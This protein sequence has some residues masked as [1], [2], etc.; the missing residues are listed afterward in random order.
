[1]VVSNI[2]K[3]AQQAGVSIATVSR[4]ING[5]ASVSPD[6]Q[7]RVMQAVNLSGYVPSVGRRVTNLIGW[8][9]AGPSSLGSP[10]DAALIEGASD[11]METSGFDLV[12]LNLKRDKQPKE[13]YSQFF[14]RKGVRGAIIRSTARDREVCSAIADEQ[15]PAIV[16]GEHFDHPDISYIYSDSKPTSYQATEHLLALGHTRIAFAASE[17]EDADHTD[18]LQG[19]RQALQEHDIEPDTKL[20][21]RIAARRLDGAQLMRNM[22]CAMHPPTAIFI[23]DPLVAVGAINEAQRLGIRIP[24]DLS[25]VGFDDTDVRNNI[26]PRMTAVCQDARHI[27]NEALSSLCRMLEDEHGRE[28]VRHVSSTWLEVNGTTGAPPSNPFRLLP[29]GT[30]VDLS[31]KI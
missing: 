11:A 27:G 8:V 1:M 5:G 2:R 4:V 13:S 3:V 22:M 10:Y 9:Y 17:T 19:Y 23:A 21:F 30:R 26:Y 12:I 20:Y 31:Q 7:A 15:F 14:L 28:P 25:V 24:E 18:R 6:V 16:L 29:D